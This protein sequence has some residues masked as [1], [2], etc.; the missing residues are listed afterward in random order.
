MRTIT[1]AQSAV[2]ATTTSARSTHV[3][4]EIYNSSQWR[5]L[6]NLDVGN[7]GVGINFVK[8]V[9]WS[10]SLGS[11]I[12]EATV[13][14][15][16]QILNF[17]LSPHI[18]S[19]L[20][21]TSL[22]AVS[23]QIRISA[24][25]MP[26]GAIPESSDYMLLFRGTI[27]RY[28]IDGN[29]ITLRCRDEMAALADAFIEN[30]GTEY[31]NGVK[32]VNE[33]IQDI[34]TQWGGGVTLYSTNGDGTPA[35]DAADLLGWVI[36]KYTQDRVPVM[37]AIRSLSDQAYADLRYKWQT[38]TGDLK[39]VLY[40]PERTAPASLRT[41]TI[42][43]FRTKSCGLNMLDIRNFIRV[44][45]FKGE[46][47]AAQREYVDADSAASI[48]LY[49]RRW[50]EINEELTSN[51]KDSTE[52]QEMADAIV[53]DLADPKLTMSVDM[54]FFP[55]VELADYYTFAADDLYYSTAQAVSVVSFS[56][57]ID[58]KGGFTQMNVEGVPKSRSTRA[59]L[60][61]QAVH[62]KRQVGTKNL[63]S[64]SSVSDSLMF[65]GDLGHWSNG[66]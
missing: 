23:A 52:A 32:E 21:Y 1:A 31:G 24:A 58:A 2:Y 44:G 27:S 34:L 22:C 12:T 43:Q 37:D 25:V 7:N 45:Y 3:K 42:D 17:N 5:E 41:F 64:F 57:T 38:V 55:N 47:K 30:T 39:L 62:Q 9:N 40:R 6:T 54:P 35:F 13:T 29:S 46:D 51:I 36:R 19:G 60:R 66:G 28:D 48:T 11:P 65:N 18:T 4:V 61:N 10:S 59:W 33:V 8:S 14:C 50:M 53:S 56:H 20:R 16:R 15:V 49:G 26:L 63:A